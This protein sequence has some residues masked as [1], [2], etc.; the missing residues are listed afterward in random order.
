VTGGFWHRAENL[1]LGKGKLADI[2][3]IPG[4]P[5]TDITVSE[6]VSFAV[7]DG[8]SSGTGR[9]SNTLI[10]Q[11]TLQKLGLQWTN[12]SGVES[13]KVNFDKGKIAVRLEL[14]PRD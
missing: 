2:I 11:W 9:S 8:K 6:R 4:D 13:A 1:H 12:R 14:L 5:T 10:K 7:K 3:A